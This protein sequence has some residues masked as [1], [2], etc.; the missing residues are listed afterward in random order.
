M[1]FL[2]PS[3]QRQSTEGKTHVYEQNDVMRDI[4]D[5]LLC[6]SSAQIVWGLSFFLDT[7]QVGQ[8]R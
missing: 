6:A 4:S 7:V 2:P 1:P 8:K 5:V 3:Q